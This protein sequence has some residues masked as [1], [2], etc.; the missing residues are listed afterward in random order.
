M[1]KFKSKFQVQS[2]NGKNRTDHEAPANMWSI[3]TS[4]QRLARVLC[5]RQGSEVCSSK[6]AECK[7]Q[8]TTST[9][10]GLMFSLVSSTP[11]HRSLAKQHISQ[12]V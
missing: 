9:T 2:P 6:H 1:D 3:L 8:T 12:N 4:G 10:G 7:L 5:D 11:Q